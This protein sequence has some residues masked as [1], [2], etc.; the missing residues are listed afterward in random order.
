MNA[1]RT[2]SIF[3]YLDCTGH[4]HT[5]RWW[6]FVLPTWILLKQKRKLKLSV[7]I[8][9]LGTPRLDSYSTESRL[10]VLTI[11]NMMKKSK[12]LSYEE[13]KKVLQ[14]HHKYLKNEL[15]SIVSKL[16][17]KMCN[18]GLYHYQSKPFLEGVGVTID[19]NPRKAH[20]LQFWARVGKNVY[21]VAGDVCPPHIPWFDGDI[22]KPNPRLKA[23]TSKKLKKHRHENRT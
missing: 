5:L 8:R 20:S 4:Q 12:N 14:E 10:L 9:M 13:F 2:A 21:Q 7:H 11:I 16:F 1:V 19:L 22:T 15:H 6:F 18:R 17:V 23:K 3:Q